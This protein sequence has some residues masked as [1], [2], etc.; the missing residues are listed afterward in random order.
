[1]P[2]YLF[3]G[4]YT[5]QGAKGLQK[6]GGSKRR[7]AAETLIKE[8]G[9]KLEAFY[10]TFGDTDFAMIAD[11]PDHISVVAASLVVNGS[12]AITMKTKH[13]ISR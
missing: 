10:Y 11:L 8:A 12:G 7:Q 1:M 6:D 9:G 4:S 5:A 2:K 3:Q 13:A